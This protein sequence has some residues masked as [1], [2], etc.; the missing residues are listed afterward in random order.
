VSSAFRARKKCRAQLTRARA[1]S[2]CKKSSGLEAGG[3]LIQI[4]DLV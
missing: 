2:Q 4:A 3:Y 1:K